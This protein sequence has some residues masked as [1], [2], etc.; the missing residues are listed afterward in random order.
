M[1]VSS[2]EEGIISCSEFGPA[3]AAKAFFFPLFFWVRGASGEV[4]KVG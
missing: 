1:S 2:V 3:A 4:L